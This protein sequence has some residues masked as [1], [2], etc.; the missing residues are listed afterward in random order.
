MCTDTLHK[1]END[2]DDDDDDDNNNNNN[3]YK[4]K[5]KKKKKKTTLMFAS[6][7]TYCFNIIKT[8]P[9]ILFR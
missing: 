1:G 9:L 8:S 4:K 7:K 5:K 2:V 3:N 6:Q